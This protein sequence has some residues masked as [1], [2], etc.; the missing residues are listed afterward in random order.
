MNL[1]NR[2]KFAAAVFDKNP[3]VQKLYKSGQLKFAS[4]IDQ[5]AKRPDVE[6]MEAINAFMK[7]N[8]VEKAGGGMLVKPSADGSRPGYASD[9]SPEERKQQT[10]RGERI[11]ET[12]KGKRVLGLT[13]EQKKWYNKTHKNNPNSR[14]YKKDWNELGGKKSDLLDS[15]FNELKREKPPKGY[16]TTKEFSKKYDFPIY[17]KRQ[18]GP[19]T[20]AESN[21]IN[22]ALMKKITAKDADKGRK[23]LFLQKFLKETLEPKQFDTVL[24]LGNGKK[25][26]KKVN[27]VKDN[28]EI[29]KKVRTYVDSPSIDPKTIQNM[30]LVLSNNKIKTLFNRGD[31][32]GIVKALGQIENL[33]NAERANVMLRVAQA[34]SGVNFRDFKHNIKTNKISAKK[35]FKGLETGRAGI[36]TEYND[37]YKK[38]KHNTIKDA[39]GLDYFTKSYQGFIDDARSALKKAGIDITN[40]DLNE[41]TGL[42]SGYKNQTFSSTQFVN[43]MDAKFNEGAHASMVGEYSRYENAL[44][45][46]LKN[47]TVNFKN[48]TFTPRQL[49]NNWQQW[50]NDW[51]DRLDDK[52]KTK[53]VRDILPTFTLGKDPYSSAISKKRLVELSGLGINLQEEGIKSGYAKTFPTIGKQPVLKEIVDMKP[54]QIKKII[55]S[56]GSGNCAVEFGKKGQRDGGRTGYK[57]GTV[58][59]D[60]CF[61][62][63]VDNMNKGNYKT[64]DQ[65]NDARGLLLKS[66][67]LLRAVTKYGVLPELA[68]I[69]L[70]SAGRTIMGDSVGDSIKKSIDTFTFG[71]TNF[72]SDIN[73]KE[74]DAAGGFGDMKLNVDKYKA[75]FDKVQALKRDIQNLEAMNAGGEFGYIGSRDNEIAFKKAAL[76]KAEQELLSSQL[77]EAQMKTIS[78]MEDNLADAKLAKSSLSKAALKDQMDGIST[79][80][81]GDYTGTDSGRMYP[82]E[83]KVNLDTDMFPSF[84]KDIDNLNKAKATGLLDIDKEILS[85]RLDAEGVD[86][87]RKKEFLGYVDYFTNLDNMTLN[88]AAAMYGDEQVYGTQGTFG[89]EAIPG[90]NVREQRGIGNYAGGGIAGLSG[91]DKSGP[92]PESGPQS[93]GL[94]GLMNRVKNR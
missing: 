13:K 77:P 87:D 16:I 64:A 52:Y 76:K 56:F 68:F 74:F 9:Y 60:D 70:E 5:P 63:G 85:Q 21:Y 32:K 58:G 53:A 72:T 65:I 81:L 71:L 6:T 26:V 48:Q 28:T 31:Y 39:I 50:R 17:E 14:F 57:T 54:A 30:N 22:N 92:A 93:Q 86:A 88:D 8:P 47:G 11:Y 61:K 1:F 66:K 45:T 78:R 40:L 19:V 91:G 29:A 20:K 15:Y 51:Y 75:N 67:N 59:L 7:R 2:I 43:F 23:N 36:P 25:S 27:Y 73:K 79:F 55:A 82:A 24:D 84:K 69:G 3:E 33:T 10:E 4:E 12:Y 49:I 46:A 18:Y 90:Y 38:L 34:M 44:K 41:I 62:S 35:I 94:Q 89:G 80:G 42:S 37:A 83:R